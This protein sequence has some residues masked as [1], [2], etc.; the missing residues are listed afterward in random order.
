[1][2]KRTTKK[3][4]E[5]LGDTVAQITKATGIDKLVKFVAGED[6][7]CDAR[8]EKLNALFPYRTPKCLTEDEYTYLTESNVLTKQTIKPSEQD[9]ILKIYN[10]IFGISR[11]PTSCATC[12][13]EIINK[14][15][16]VY[17]EY[18]TE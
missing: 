5:G 7:G 14:M 1:M 4:S 12:W 13:M 6:C 10:R 16:K 15:Q 9:A 18:I 11:E 17:N 2:E 3:K 8:K